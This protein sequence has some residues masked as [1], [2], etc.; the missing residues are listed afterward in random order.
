MARAY[1]VLQRR[2]PRGHLYEDLPEFPERSFGN[3]TID[4]R[5]GQNVNNRKAP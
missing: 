1:N 3:R 2:A 5:K 4:T